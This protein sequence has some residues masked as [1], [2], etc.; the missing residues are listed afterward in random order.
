MSCVGSS[1]ALATCETSQ[2]LLAGVPG[3]FSR[4]SPVFA[5]L[6]IGPSHMSCNNLER[7]V[8]KKK[9]KAQMSS[10][11]FI[12]NTSAPGPLYNTVHYK[13]VLGITLIIVGCANGHFRLI[14]YIFTIYLYIL[15]PF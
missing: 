15:L 12:V 3:G 10:F 8:K 9:K 2:V 14:Y 1:P 5:H 7:D 13:A 11:S 6:L 4:G